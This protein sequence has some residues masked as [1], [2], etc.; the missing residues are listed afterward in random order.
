MGNKLK[1]GGVSAII[2]AIIAF[3]A[4]PESCVSSSQILAWLP[5]ALDPE[6]VATIASLVAVLIAAFSEKLQVTKSGSKKAN[7]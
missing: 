5:F 4:H 3:F 7:P 6:T 1:L 2:L